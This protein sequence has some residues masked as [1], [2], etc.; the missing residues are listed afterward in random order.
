[1][2]EQRLPLVNNDDGIWGEVLNQYIGK[3]HYNGDLDLN[4]ATSE[5]GG[6]QHVT[7]QP[8]TATA[9]TAPLR[10]T[11]GTLLSAPAPGAIE[12]NSDRFYITQVIN[13]ITNRRVI[14]AYDDTSGAAG[15]I[16]YRDSV[17]NFT[18][19][20][21]GTT[22]GSVL[23]VNSS[24]LPVWGPAIDATATASTIV[25]RNASANIVT[26][27]V[28]DGYVATATSGGTTTLDV[29]SAF[30][31]RFT[32]ATTQTVV[33]PDVSTLVVGQRWHIANSSTGAD[34]SG[35]ITVQSS[36]LNTIV[37]LPA[38]SYVILTCVS[39]TGTGPGSWSYD[40]STSHITV[41]KTQP[42]LAVY[43]DIWIDIN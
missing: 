40:Q 27:N 2:Q 22:T 4:P 17:G 37:V 14:A 41:S 6:H 25:Q 5:N 21:I 11:N 38:G 10:F 16:Y 9:G 23:N 18:R 32:G 42:T 19:L 20:P 31:Q 36:G 12:Y 39:L 24:S 26:N 28:I 30:K 3:E 1:M 15:D 43:G 7:L 13:S 35:A 29:N 33:M 8:G 34:A